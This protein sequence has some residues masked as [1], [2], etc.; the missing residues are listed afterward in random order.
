MGVDDFKFASYRLCAVLLC[1]VVG[2]SSIVIRGTW[3][4]QRN[5]FRG[6]FQKDPIPHSGENHGKV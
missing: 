4:Y 6:V 2:L 5:A 3:N 1:C